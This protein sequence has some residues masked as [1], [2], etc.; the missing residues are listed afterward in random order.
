MPGR[1]L[2]ILLAVLLSLA[3]LGGCGSTPE[4]GAAP[5]VPPYAAGHPLPTPVVFAEGIVSTGRECNVT[6][7]P[8]GTEVYF[9]RPDSTRTH[10]HLYRS[11]FEEGRWQ[12]AEQIAFSDDRY[13][14]LDPF[15]SPDGARLYFASSRPVTGDQEQNHHDLWYAER[16]ASGWAK[17]RRLGAAVNTDAKEGYP[18][19]TRDGTL[20]F[21][22]ERP[23]G[24]GEMD[25]YRA[26]PQEGLYPM[27][28]NLDAVNTPLRDVS[29][30][31]APDES[32]LVF[33]HV[34]AAGN[35]DLY[36][37]Y[38]QQGVWTPPEPLRDVVN[39]DADEVCP[40][41][42]PDGRSLFFARFQ[43]RQGRIYQVD[44]DATG[45]R[46]P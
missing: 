37:S 45:L 38:H 9:N 28:E 12:D 25:L 11:R 17:P 34:D 36:V 20:Y 3:V 33:Y 29:P 8:D 21:F 10:A 41:V 44:V 5:T 19:V 2:P 30:Y 32:Y 13:S 26:L 6:F 18:S 7:S 4:Q 43:N 40:T 14:D 39:T 16:T 15:V 46:T 42:S 27:V 35:A 31:V 22:S 24:H 23:G 1:R